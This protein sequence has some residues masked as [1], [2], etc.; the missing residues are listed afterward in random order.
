VCSH[1]EQLRKRYAEDEEFRQK[2]IAYACAYHKAHKK[3]ILERRRRRRETDPAYRQKLVAA[4]KAYRE[5]NKEEL[6]ERRRRKR[7]TDPEHRDKRLRYIYGISLEEYDAMLERQGGVCAICKKAPARGKV[8]FVDHCHVTGR[9]RGLLCAKC[10]SVLAFGHDDLDILRAAIAYLQAARE[11]DRNVTAQ[12]RAG[13][14]GRAM[15]PP[16]IVAAETKPYDSGV[17]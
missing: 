9:V 12:E 14:S 15:R 4:A 11:R 13:E 17:T 2:K 10:N 5:A 3:E 7:Q 8:L 1:L 16:D 6:S